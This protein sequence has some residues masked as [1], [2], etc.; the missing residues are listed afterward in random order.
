MKYKIH[1]AVAQ[2]E[3]V[4]ADFDSPEE[5]KQGY[6]EVKKAYRKMAKKHHPDKLQNL[7]KEHIKVAEE[8]F[9]KIQEAYEK[10]KDERRF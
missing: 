2:Y 6:D 1:V 10:I 8:K 5:A 9:L 3:F 7:G 4:E